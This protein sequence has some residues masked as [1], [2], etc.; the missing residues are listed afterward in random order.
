M[1]ILLEVWEDDMFNLQSDSKEEFNPMRKHCFY[2]IKQI[3]H[4]TG[5]I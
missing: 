5:I 4:Q 3:E 1:Y 2:G